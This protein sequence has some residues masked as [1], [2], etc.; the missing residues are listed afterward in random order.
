MIY[1]NNSLSRSIRV[2][3]SLY[4]IT[5]FSS[6]SIREL[7]A[8]FPES[9]PLQQERKVQ[10]YDSIFKPGDAIQI[11]VFPDTSSFL[12]NIFP[13]D[14]KGFVFLPIVG[15]TQVVAMSE[16]EFINFLSKNFTQYLRTPTIQVRP[17]IRVS[18]LGG[19]I[20]P[21]LYY[22]DPNS[23]LWDVIY[24]AGGTIRE[25]G[26]KKM[27]WERNKKNIETDLIPYIQSGKSLAEI[28]FR[29]GDQIW[30]PTPGIPSFWDN[31]LRYGMPLISVGISAYTLY[32]TTQLAFVRYRR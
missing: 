7:R 9:R 26:L 27:R 29:S 30:T 20:R 13:I 4:L 5:F 24:R 23:T 10:I 19:F 25:E 12:H 14:G 6:Y 1:L 3:L 28:G 21:S 17:L 15:K 11:S 2:M 22:V 18:V 31:L 8:D 16:T 32:Y